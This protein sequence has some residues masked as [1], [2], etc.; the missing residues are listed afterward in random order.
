MM[1]NSAF[2]VKMEELVRQVV[3]FY[4]IPCYLVDSKMETHTNAYGENV[5]IPVV[6]IVGFFEDTIGKVTHLLNNEFD[7]RLIND[8]NAGVDSFTSSGQTYQ[9]GLKSNRL[10]LPEYKILGP[11]KFE[12]RVSSILQD[13][14]TAMQKGLSNGSASLPDNVR[15]DFYRVGAFLEMA[16][17]EFVKIRDNVKSAAPAGQAPVAPVP[18]I[19]RIERE[20]KPVE[21]VPVPEPVAT[22]PVAPVPEPSPAAAPQ[23]AV[24]PEQLTITPNEADKNKIDAIDMSVDSFN[25]LAV[26]INSIEKKSDAVEEK[27]LDLLNGDGSS[28]KNG[29]DSSKADTNATGVTSFDSQIADVK[30]AAGGSDSVALNIDTVETFNMNVNGMI[31]KTTEIIREGGGNNTSPGILDIPNPADK[32]TPTNLDE[33]SQ[34]TEASLKEFIKNSKLVKEVDSMVAERAGAKINEEIDIEGDVDRLRFLKVFTLKQLQERI[35]D[36]KEDIVSFAEKW[37]GK[38]NGGSFDSGI[39]LFYLEYLLVGK[40]NDPA[41]AVEYVLK[42]I[43]DNDYSARYIIP[44]YNS[45]RQTAEPSSFAHLTL[46]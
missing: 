36:N 40:K 27:Y 11:H 16:D 15:R 45:I 14:Y 32:S 1:S 28:V 10:E 6:R 30:P 31:E 23:A 21:T 37:I 43:S 33:N 4:N 34:M 9:A 18:E 13:V 38:D 42:F 35:F 29:F 24:A 20:T 41:F 46:K 3:N 12:I 7:L 22:Q 17:I 2:L 26:D 44:T 5:R 39:C 25:S 8:E 19:P